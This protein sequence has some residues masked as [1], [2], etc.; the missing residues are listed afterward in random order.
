[1]EATLR[2]EATRDARALAVELRRAVRGLAEQDEAGVADQVEQR[3]VLRGVARERQGEAPEPRS[4][5]SRGHHGA[6]ASCGSAHAPPRRSRTSSS[7]VSE[8]SSYQ[9]PTARNGSG[10]ARQMV[11]SATARS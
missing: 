5:D 1:M 3:V 4:G 10:V 9:S 2:D 7:D 6:P 11:S 8:K